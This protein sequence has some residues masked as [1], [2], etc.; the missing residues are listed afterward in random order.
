M[1]AVFNNSVKISVKRKSLNFL[2]LIGICTISELLL[3]CSSVTGRSDKVILKI[4][5][6][7]QH[8]CPINFKHLSKQNLMEMS[9]SQI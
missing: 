1:Y 9:S 8:F 7:F 3:F 4:Q 5:A 2:I 6:I